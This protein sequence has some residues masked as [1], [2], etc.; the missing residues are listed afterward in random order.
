MC[1]FNFRS[2]LRTGDLTN[3]FFKNLESRIVVLAQSSGFVHKKMSGK[4]GGAIVL[5]EIVSH[6]RC[7]LR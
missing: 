2:H 5:G 6:L 1:I 7:D 4:V 3:D